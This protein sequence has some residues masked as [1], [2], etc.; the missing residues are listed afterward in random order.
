[1][2]TPFNMN[3]RKNCEVIDEQHATG[4]A[5]GVPP[6]KPYFYKSKAK[7]KSQAAELN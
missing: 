3:T 5:I 1:M 7:L 6:R 2:I 4:N